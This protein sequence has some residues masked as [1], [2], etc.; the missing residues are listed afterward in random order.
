MTVGENRPYRVIRQGYG[1]YCG[2]AGFFTVVTVG[3]MV[4]A[5]REGKPVWIYPLVGL[6]LIVT[7]WRATRIRVEINEASCRIVSL[8]DSV[9]VPWADIDRFSFEAGAGP[10]GMQAY[11]VRQDGSRVPIVA[12]QGQIWR[13]RTPSAA[14]TDLVRELNRLLNEPRRT[15]G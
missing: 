5:A 15:S 7:S 10:F 6:P 12:I 2:A 4:A 11:C 9:T 14:S 13:L 1:W 8:F 3:M